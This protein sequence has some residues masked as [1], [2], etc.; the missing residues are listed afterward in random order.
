[1][2]LV[3]LLLHTTTSEVCVRER[4]S[5]SS[6]SSSSACSN[7]RAYECS[8]QSISWLCSAHSVSHCESSS[9]ALLEWHTGCSLL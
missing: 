4:E 8:V 5:G 6:S 7:V 2:V 1:M 3:S 9:C